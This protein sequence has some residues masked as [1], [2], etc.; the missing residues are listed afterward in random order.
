MKLTEPI[1]KIMTIDI[2]AVKPNTSLEEMKRLM[3]RRGFH[4]LPVESNEGELLGLVSAEDIA[5]VERAYPSLMSIKAE[6]FM[7]TDLVKLSL[8]TSIL[9]ALDIFLENRY[10]ALPVVDTDNILVGIVT[11]YDFLE[12]LVKEK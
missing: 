11:P 8:D 9:D 2:T 5:R 6:H 4:H 3:A 10:R 12:K 1:S 7:T